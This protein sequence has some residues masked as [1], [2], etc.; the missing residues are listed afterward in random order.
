MPEIRYFHVI[1]VQTW[2]RNVQIRYTCKAVVLLIKPIAFLTFS[3]PSASLDL[4]VPIKSS[5]ETLDIYFYGHNFFAV[6]IFLRLAVIIIIF[7][8]FHA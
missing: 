2:K 7:F 3:L 1:V 5:G 4:K 6:Y 8:N